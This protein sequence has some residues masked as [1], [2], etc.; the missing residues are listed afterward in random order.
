L[1]KPVSTPHTAHHGTANRYIQ[2]RK[3]EEGRRKKE[4]V[5]FSNGFKSPPI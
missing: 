2:R 4:E 1:V 5:F 3:R